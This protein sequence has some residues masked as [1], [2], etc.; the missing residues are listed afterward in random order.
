MS[1]PTPGHG[2][3]AIYLR[4]SKQTEQS[5]SLDAQLAECM[6]LCERNGWTDTRIYRDESRSASNARRKRP[7][8]ERMLADVRAGQVAR[9]VCRDDDRLVRQPIELE[10][11]IN[12]LEP[13]AVPVWF[14]AG[15]ELDLTTSRGR[16]N[17]RIR[18]AIARGEV[19]R[20]SERQKASNRHR[21]AS[22]RPL[23]TVRPF[24][25]TYA[26]GALTV[27][28]AEAESIRWAVGHVM[29][30]G[31]LSDV[32]REWTARGHTVPKTKGPYSWAAAKGA[33]TNPYICGH[34]QYQPSTILSPETSKRVPG[35][36]AELIRGE[37]EPIISREQ[38]TDV[39]QVLTRTRSKAGNYVRYL[40]A[41]I[42]R[43]GICD[44][45]LRSGWNANKTKRWRTYKCVGHNGGISA[46]PIDDYVTDMLTSLLM[47]DDF[48]D[49]LAEPGG[50]DRGALEAERKE[51]E[52][53]LEA[54][55]AA[56][57]RRAIRLPQLEAG[58]A[59]IEARLAEIGDALAGTVEQEERAARYAPASREQWESATI[60]QRRLFLR[61][62]LPVVRV[63]P[64][65][66]NPAPPVPVYVHAY[67]RRGRLR[68]LPTGPDE[69]EL[70]ECQAA[71][72]ERYS[73]TLTN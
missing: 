16:E 49:F 28:P 48:A 71:H 32:A 41:G 67:D 60:E 39:V 30:G 9:I 51:L 31:T 62:L 50:P 73:A 19:E 59:A 24:G 11:L 54:L 63:F 1:T 2:A 8:Y 23:G 13:G 43:C 3:T 58:T 36:R 44:K 47:A 15:S 56:Y 26:S 64:A 40:G 7:A 69:I 53:E 10:G 52:A 34:L 61:D 72:A 55:T 21:V 17:A 70:A 5:V 27:V 66:S 35:W 4:L 25:Y 33:L 18:G 12:T 29:R 57:T 37:W 22:G 14:A 38:W 65:G 45:P 68:P 42:Y 46:D 6:A 20:K